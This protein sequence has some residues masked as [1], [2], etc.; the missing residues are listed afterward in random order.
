MARL[1][2]IDEQ[3]SKATVCVGSPNLDNRRFEKRCLI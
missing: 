2:G 3:E 1:L